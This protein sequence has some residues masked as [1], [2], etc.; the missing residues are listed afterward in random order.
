MARW[1][2]R[3]DIPWSTTIILAGQDSRRRAIPKPRPIG[4][5]TVDVAARLV[6]GHWR[7]EILRVGLARR[8]QVRRAPD[9]P[10]SD[11]RSVRAGSE[12]VRHELSSKRDLRQ[13]VCFG[14]P[15]CAW[16][17]GTYEKHQWLAAAVR[18]KESQSGCIGPAR[19]SPH[20]RTTGCSWNLK[21]VVHRYL[22]P[23][24]PVWLRSDGSTMLG[25]TT[26]RTTGG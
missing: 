5:R 9:A 13:D 1:L 16:Q 14:D 2:M 7:A 20:C 10:G 19:R 21:P 18:S 17:R 23:T 4:A 11:G 6:R 25:G 8:W 12:T 3:G 22:P 24:L 15:R 26:L